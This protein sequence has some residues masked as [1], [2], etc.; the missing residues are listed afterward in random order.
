VGASIGT[1]IAPTDGTNREELIRAADVAMYDAKTNQ[2]LHARYSPDRDPHSRD[3]LELIEDLRTAI[4]NRAFEMHYQPTIAVGTGLVV[5][6]EALIR[7]NHPRRGMMTPDHFIPLAERV[8]LIPAITRAVLDISIAHLADTLRNG[9]ELRLSVNISA[10]DLVDDDLPRYIRSTLDAN[11]VPATLLTLEITET[12]LSGDT[13]RAERTLNALRDLGIRVS[14]DDFG[15]GYSS[16]SQLLKLPLD[17]LKIDRS[18]I[19]NLHTDIRARAILAAT[20]ELGR[21][22]GLDIVAEGIETA[23]ALSEITERGVESAQGFY[24]SKAL[25]P[26]AF[27]RFVSDQHPADEGARSS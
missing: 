10:L 8:G 23:E 25:A 26:L 27:E 15:V 6:M 19:A 20:V 1:A 4:D 7:W 24:F 12:A 17:E 13:V 3:R 14:I 9:H 5:G 2:L 22:L 21:T 18:F 11:Q 16:M